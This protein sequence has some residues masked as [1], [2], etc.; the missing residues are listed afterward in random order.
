MELNEPFEGHEHA[1]T[2]LKVILLVFSIV[3]IGALAY[4]MGA[5]YGQPE[6]A[7]EVAPSVK[8]KTEGQTT[9]TEEDGTEM[10]NDETV[11]WTTYS[12]TTPQISFKYPKEIYKSVTERVDGL[13]LYKESGEQW[14]IDLNWKKASSNNLDT[15]TAAYISDAGVSASEY[16]KTSTTIGGAPATKIVFTGSE[17]GY[18]DTAMLVISKG[19]VIRFNY[20]SKTNGKTFETML[21]TVSFN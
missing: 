13:T 3:V 8:D 7:E 16:T 9:T 11:G 17:V 10:V 2:S 6:V 18:G 12:S 15:E 4:L 19:Y 21:T 14:Q 20:D 5:T 1:T